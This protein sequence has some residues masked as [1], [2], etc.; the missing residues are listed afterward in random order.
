MNNETLAAHG[1]TVASVFI[2]FSQSR[3]RANVKHPS[4]NWSVTIQR[5]G[6]PVLTCDYSAGAAHCPSYTRD[7][8]QV[9]ANRIKSECETGTHALSSMAPPYFRASGKPIQPNAV[10]V[11][12]SVML[13]AS[14]LDCAGFAD[15]CADYG[16]SDDS[17]KARA[18]YD[19]CIAHGLAMR[20]ALGSTA[21][22]SLREAFQNY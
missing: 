18:I 2:P 13:D 12:A 15:W 17:V 21:F 1:L 16:Y 7:N 22:D 20:A 10:D 4:L 19:S 14:A 6:R 11:V 3:N 9:T 5:N 8:L